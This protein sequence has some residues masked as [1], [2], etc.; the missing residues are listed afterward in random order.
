VT[1]ISEQ[2]DEAVVDA[3]FTGNE[4]IAVTGVSAIKGTWLG[5]GGE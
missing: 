5:L 3:P 2:V 1:V 4:Q